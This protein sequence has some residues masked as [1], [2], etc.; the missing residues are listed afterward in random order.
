M[1]VNKTF[2]DQ[3]HI[4]RLNVLHGKNQELQPRVGYG[5]KLDDR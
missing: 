5:A 4:I 2:T 3:H 1:R